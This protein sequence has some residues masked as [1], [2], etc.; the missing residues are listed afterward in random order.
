MSTTS[1]PRKD[2][3][4]VLFHHVLAQRGLLTLIIVL[5]IVSS[6]VSLAQPALIRQVI[7]RVSNS[8]ALDALPWILGGLVVFGGLLGGVVQYLIQRAAETAVRSSR[9]RLI[10]HL[11]R[12]PIPYID[13]RRVGDL[14]SRVSNDTTTIRN[15]LSQGLIESFAGVFTLIGAFI[16][17]LL[18]DSLLLV[19]AA[20]TALLAVIIVVAVTHHIENASIGLQESVGQLTS[21]VDRALRAVRTVRAANAT[22]KE[23]DRVKADADTAWQVGLRVA[24]TTALVAPISSVAMQTSFL[25]VLGVGGLRVASGILTVADLV[26][27]IMF[28]LL[29]IIPL[30][31]IFGTMSAIGEALGGATRIAEILRAP[32]ESENGELTLPPLAHIEKLLEFNGVGF[33]YESD[34]VGTSPASSQQTL[35]GVSFCIEQGQKVAIV[36]P[37]GAGKSTILNLIA[38]FYD[39]SYGTIRFAGLDMMRV[40]RTAIRQHLAYVEQGAPAISGTIRD[41]LMLTDLALDDRQI[42]KMLADLNLLELIERSPGGLDTEVGENGVLLS[43][44]ERQRLAL[45]RVLLTQPTLLLLDESTSNLDGVNEERVQELLDR[46]AKTHTRLIVAHRLSTV[47]DADLILVLSEGRIIAQGTHAELLDASEAYQ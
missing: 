17:M 44:G 23:A 46:H 28:L 29:L 6:G 27:F 14:V 41:N 7:D 43:G 15:M 8:Q 4:H 35:S 2:G 1:P 13:R 32:I 20:G 18:I 21:S 37:S 26:S 25:A 24:K 5:S 19:I 42:H 47:I 33:T 3:L 36:G 16:A 9:H 12:L 30:G 11:L 39:P 31:Q 40:S 38:R 45:A 34:G 22:Q 10:D